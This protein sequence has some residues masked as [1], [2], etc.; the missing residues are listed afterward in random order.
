MVI[1]TSTSET[2]GTEVRIRGI[3]TSGNNPGLEPS[4]GIFVDNV[5]RS[6]SGLAVGDLLDIASVEI[7]RGPQGTLF[8]RNTSA[9]TISINTLKPE[10]GGGYGEGTVQNY[11]GYQ[12]AAGVTGPVVNDT[13]AFRLA[14][15]FNERDGYVSDRLVSSRE[16]YDRNRANVRGQLLWRP[17]EDVDVRLIVDYKHKDEHCCAADY[18]IAG[19][20]AAAIESLGGI[21]KP[22]P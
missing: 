3:G 17:D 20:T 19:P 8:G 18:T 15:S 21:V 5:Y 9:G 7:L 13:L 6:R 12:V 4:V 2:A 22:P 16:L 1:T 10:F 14:T 11:N